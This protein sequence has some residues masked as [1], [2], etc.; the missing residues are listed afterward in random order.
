MR[1]LL[2]FSCLDNFFLRT[3][4][5]FFVAFSVS[6]DV[7]SFKGH[8]HIFRVFFFSVYFHVFSPN[9]YFLCHPCLVQKSRNALLINIYK[10]VCLC[11]YHDQG[12]A[13]RWSLAAADW[14]SNISGTARSCDPSMRLCIHVRDHEHEPHMSNANTIKNILYIIS[15]SKS[16]GR[17]RVWS[18]SYHGNGE[19]IFYIY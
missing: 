9:M 11:L 13:L 3:F 16:A 7:R 10:H 8:C 14:N 2:S 6:F 18:S 5:C 12:F 19:L 1:F 4:F 17:S 15:D